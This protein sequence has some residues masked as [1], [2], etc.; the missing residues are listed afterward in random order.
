MN[1]V[2]NKRKDEIYD[3]K[4]NNQSNIFTHPIVMSVLATICCL[5]WGSAFPAI[6]LGYQ[7]VCS[8]FDCCSGI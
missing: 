5:L 8:N 6:K 2:K 7:C 4:T 3:M 1:F